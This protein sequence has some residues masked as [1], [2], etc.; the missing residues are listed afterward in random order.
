M[1][2]VADPQKTPP[3]LPVG[4]RLQIGTVAGFKSEGRPPSRRYGWPASH[5]YARPASIGILNYL[6]FPPATLLPNTSRLCQTVIPD[7]VKPAINCSAR[8]PGNPG[9]QTDPATSQSLSFRGREASAA[10]FVENRSHLSKSLA[11]SLLLRNPNH[12]RRL[13]QAIPAGE[14]S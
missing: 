5:R 9:H 13:R 10:L 4:G 6:R 12:A 1:P 7:V 11:N 2:R 3:T 8:Q 14:S